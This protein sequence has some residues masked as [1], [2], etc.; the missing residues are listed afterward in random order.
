MQGAQAPAPVP[1]DERV[2]LFLDVQNVV[3]G[4]RDYPGMSGL[5]PAVFFDFGL[6]LEAAAAGRRV[7]SATAYDA[8]HLSADPTADDPRSVRDQL[9]RL[10]DRLGACGWSLKLRDLGYEHAQKGVDSLLYSDV[11]RGAYDD[12]YDTAVIISGDSDFAESVRVAKSKGRKAEV[13]SFSK[14]LSRHMKESADSVTL[15]DSLPLI[16]LSSEEART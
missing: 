12:T 14:P 2:A 10:H 9:Q 5:D 6:L 16:V 3:I 11:M 1:R 4:L 15:L 7:V 13:M 8:R